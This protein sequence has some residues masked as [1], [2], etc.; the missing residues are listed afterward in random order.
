[1]LREIREFYSKTKL[2]SNTF[3]EPGEAP[4]THIHVFHKEYPRLE[5]ISM[6]GAVPAGELYD[7]LYSRESSRRFSDEPI[8]FATLSAI[9]RSC[10]ITDTARTPERRTYPSAGA[11]FP[12]ETYLVAFNVAGIGCG[13]YHYNISEHC[14]ETLLSG[15][16]EARAVDF[17]TTYLENPAAALVFTAVIPRSEVKYG[18]RSYQYS[19][20]EAGHICQNAHLACTKF[21][22]GS[23]PVGGFVND[24]VSKILD[25]TRD[26]LPLYVLG[27]GMAH[28]D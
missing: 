27:L 8:A 19:L 22:V 1:M 23:C 11:R 4:I 20:I 2:A 12:V 21:G 3:E 5:R 13:A 26:E 14:L 6:P 17:C 16:L 15:N 25:L 18:I 7:L 28:A 10:G 9:L 24:S